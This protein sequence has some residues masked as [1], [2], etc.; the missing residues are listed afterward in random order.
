MSEELEILKKTFIQSLLSRNER[1]G[2]TVK[3]FCKKIY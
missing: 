2:Y 1:N 3:F